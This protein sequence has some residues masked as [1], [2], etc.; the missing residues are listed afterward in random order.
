MDLSSLNASASDDK[1]EGLMSDVEADEPA[2]DSS[3]NDKSKTNTAGGVDPL[4]ALLM[5]GGNP[6]GDDSKKPAPDLSFGEKAL[7]PKH[8]EPM[9]A[10]GPKVTAENVQA[11]KPLG[12]NPFGVEVVPDFSMGKEA[13]KPKKYVPKKSY[14]TGALPEDQEEENSSDQ[15]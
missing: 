13:L 6:F 3:S 14:E 15:Q 9:K 11:N 12:D 8:F 10:S 7:K 1:S 4:M 5:A 2:K